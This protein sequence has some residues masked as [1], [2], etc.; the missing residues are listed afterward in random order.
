MENCELVKKLTNRLVGVCLP[1]EAISR[2]PDWGRVLVPWVRDDAFLEGPF[3]QDNLCHYYVLLRRGIIDQTDKKVLLLELGVG[4][5]TSRIIKLPFWELT[6]KNENV[7]YAC[8]NRETSH[9]QSICGDIAC[10][11]KEIWRKV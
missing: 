11:C 10:I 4:E 7:F 5:I 6:A 3:W 9:G 2:Y 1:E 8:L